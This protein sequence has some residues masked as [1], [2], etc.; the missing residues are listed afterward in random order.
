MRDMY[1]VMYSSPQHKMHSFI[2]SHSVIE[3]A[4]GRETGKTRKTGKT[5]KTEILKKRKK[6]KKR[7]N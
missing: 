6:R 4:T 3:T 1:Y 5:G 2:H 7:K